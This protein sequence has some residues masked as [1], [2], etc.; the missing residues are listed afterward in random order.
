LTILP[1]TSGAGKQQAGSARE[2]KKKAEIKFLSN[3]PIKIM[4]LISALNNGGEGWWKGKFPRQGPQLRKDA[5][6]N[7]YPLRYP[8]WL[9]ACAS[10]PQP[11][12]PPD[13]PFEK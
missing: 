12:M 13:W 2:K 10:I 9:Q 8:A 4:K 7:A 3:Q 5:G 1:E 11:M 6:R